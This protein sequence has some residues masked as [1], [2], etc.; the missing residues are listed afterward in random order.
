MLAAPRVKLPSTVETRIEHP[1]SGVFDV[2]VIGSSVMDGAPGSAGILSGKPVYTV[3]LQVGTPKEWMLQYCI[4]NL[5]QDPVVSGS[6]VTIGNP[7]PVRAPYPRMTV[8]PPPSLL[9][10]D[11]SVMIHGYLDDSGHFE[12]L[13]LLG[14]DGSEIEPNVIPFL[15]QW[16]FRPATRDGMPVQIEVLLVIPPFQG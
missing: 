4:P 16:T 8:V 9:L 7:S 6:V 15:E 3:Y 1:I 10:A 5:S 11:R 2:V 13:R 12:D 14:Q